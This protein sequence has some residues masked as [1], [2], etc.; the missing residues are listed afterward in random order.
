MTLE[1]KIKEIVLEYYPCEQC[2]GYDTEPS[3]SE[4]VKKIMQ[5]IK[6]NKCVY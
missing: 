3:L 6:E 2:E 5:E 4:C 1:E